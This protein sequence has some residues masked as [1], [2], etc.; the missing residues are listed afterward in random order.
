MK[1]H[2]LLLIGFQC[3]GGFLFAQFNKGSSLLPHHA[4]VQYAGN[5]GFVS[6]GIGYATK[7]EKLQAD[8]YYGYLPKRIGGTTIHSI[9]GKF[10][11]S[12]IDRN[13]RKADIS[14]LNLG[15]LVNYAF[16]DQYFLF[17]PD[18]YPYN[19]Y[20]FPTAAFVGLVVGGSYKKGPYNFYYE[21][22]AADRDM[23]SFANNPSSIKFTEIWSFGAGVK[24]KLRKNKGKQRVLIGNNIP[25]ASGSPEE[26]AAYSCNW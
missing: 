5:I 12:L 7:N 25:P 21:V 4:Q 3:L 6:A 16:G 1:W 23:I 10:T 17:S 9:T 20:R 8:L 2:C 18:N 24:M 19:Y 13:Y 11:A 15:F 14:F 26:I 22:V